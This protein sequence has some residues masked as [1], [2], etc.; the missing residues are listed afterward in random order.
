MTEDGQTPLHFIINGIGVSEDMY[1]VRR[2]FIHELVVGKG[3]NIH[4]LD[5][6]GR[7][8]LWM[9]FKAWETGKPFSTHHPIE[10]QGFVELVAS[11]IEFITET[12]VL[13][14]PIPWAGN[15]CSLLNWA[16]CLRYVNLITLLLSKGFDVDL[17]IGTPGG[18]IIRSAVETACFYG[19]NIDC[20][21]VLLER[22]TRLFEP[23]EEGHY[24]SHLVCAGPNLTTFP[25]EKLCEYSLD[26]DQRAVLSSKTPIMLAAMVGK[27]D[28]VKFLFRHNVDLRAKDS[29][30]WEVC[31][32]AASSPNPQLLKEFIGRDVDWNAKVHMRSKGEYLASCSVL[33]I[34]TA[35]GNPENV[36]L[37]VHESLIKDFDVLNGHGMS[38]LH[39]AAGHGSAEM[40]E[41]LIQAGANIDLK[42]PWIDNGMRPI[43]MAISHGRRTTTQALLRHGCSLAPDAQ[44]VTLELF[45]L[46]YKQKEIISILEEYISE[47]GMPPSFSSC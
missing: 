30:S 32:W 23:D 5:K 39:I 9:V 40:V 29:H 33:H 13:H 7:S 25:L 24:L 21:D 16:I 2:H 15:T 19:C 20:L 38:P 34:A 3:A 43:H 47:I 36:R 10:Q 6:E 28:H 1:R 8:C 46:K 18:N 37:I 35:S 27:Q 14:Q 44:G 22:S 45:A 42:S 4:A 17:K 31:H 12:A 26:W 11:I 41:I